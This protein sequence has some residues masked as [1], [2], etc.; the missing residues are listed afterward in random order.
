MTRHPALVPLREQTVDFY[1][2][3]LAWLHGWYTELTG[4]NSTT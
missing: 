4:E 3:V 2:A 1:D